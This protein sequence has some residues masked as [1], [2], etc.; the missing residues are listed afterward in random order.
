MYLN[1]EVI[2]LESLILVKNIIR[3]NF[4]VLI[5]NIVE[6]EQN[7]E[8][9]GFSFSIKKK[10]FRSRK[11]KKT[12][13]KKGYFVAFWEKDSNNVNKPYDEETSP[14]KLVINI[15]DN[16]KIGQFIFPKKILVDKK[17]LTSV[18]SKGKMA[19][20]IYPSW[21]DNLNYNA[22][23]TQKWQL[24]YFIDLSD[25][26]DQLNLEKLYFDN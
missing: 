10:R 21:C 2:K 15:I 7:L 6:E 1:G 13:K 18:D 24:D 11:A 12:L 17:I 20:R 5:D 19:I 14:E 25:Q 23:S 9:E 4:A 16:D 22:V 26:Y 8:Y 3:N